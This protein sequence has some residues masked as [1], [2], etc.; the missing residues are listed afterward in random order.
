MKKTIAVI[1]IAIAFIVG[2]TFVTIKAEQ[3][4]AATPNGGSNDPPEGSGG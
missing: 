4:Y 1:M 2:T 3:V